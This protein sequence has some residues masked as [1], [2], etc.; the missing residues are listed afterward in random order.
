MERITLQASKLYA[1]NSARLQAPPPE[2]ATLARA[3]RDN[4]GIR[5]VVI[6]GHTDRLGSA[7]ANERLSL[8]R[9]ESVKAWLV[10]NGVAADRLGTRG[11]G[12]REPKV[13]CAQQEQRALVAC[14]EPNRRVEVEPVTVEKRP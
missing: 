7:A 3:L 13:Q 11:V 12:S 8:A 4:P 9:A 10:A 14:L 2:L 5:G 6:T 1:F